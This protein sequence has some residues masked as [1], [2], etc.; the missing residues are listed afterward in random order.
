MKSEAERRIEWFRSMRPAGGYRDGKEREL[1]FFRA[2]F[3]PLPEPDP[4]PKSLGQILFERSGDTMPWAKLAQHNRDQFESDAKA[5]ITAHEARRPKPT[6]ETVARRIL[7]VAYV[8]V[9]WEHASE[10]VKETC[11]DYARAVFPLFGVEP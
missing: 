11:S 6:V 8:S 7:K 3:D 9:S 5:I 4:E 10:S 2:I 1:H